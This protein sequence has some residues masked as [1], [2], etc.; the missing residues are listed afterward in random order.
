MSH[1]K[2]AGSTKN[3]RDSRAK[4][5]G[6]KVFGGQAV[7]AGDIIVR[8]QGNKFFPGQNV[9]QGRDFTLYA[10]SDGVVAFTEKRS[11]KFDGRVY[12]DMVVHVQQ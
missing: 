9:G 4:R 6:V 11:K 10:E 3:G 5:L 12:R 1:K 8:Q 7:A 2:A